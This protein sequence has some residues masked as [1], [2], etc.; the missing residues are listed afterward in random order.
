[1]GIRRRHVGHDRHRDAHSTP[2]PGSYHARLLATSNGVTTSSNLI[3]ITAGARPTATIIRL[4]TGRSSR[5]ARADLHRDR[6]RSGRRSRY[7]LGA[8]LEHRL[9]AQRT[10]SPGREW[11]GASFSYTVPTAGHDFTGNTRY[12]VTLTAK[13]ADGLTGTKV[14]T[15]Y[16]RKTKVH[17]SSN[18]STS[19]TVDA[20]TQDLP[21]DI[22]TVIG[23]HHEISVPAT[24]CLSGTT[25]QFAS[26]NDGGAR[27][28][29][30][31]VSA[32]LALV[33]TYNGTSAACTA[34]G[35][36]LQ[37]VAP[38]A[39]EPATSAPV[40]DEPTTT[41]APAAE[42][43]TTTPSTATDETTTLSAAVP[44]P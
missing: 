16:P 22:D 19:M 13:D 23:F 35:G 4:R 42:E 2:R 32:N 33:A 6:K 44:S 41:P 40:V 43:L 37:R 21:F 30:V 17:I 34:V 14:V 10:R 26:W 24:V 8:E 7:R 5:P 12:R 28:H 39:D 20:V 38:A 18:A 29:T 1:M 15:V 31:T 36:Q 27:T 25:R 9:P 3:T 11:T